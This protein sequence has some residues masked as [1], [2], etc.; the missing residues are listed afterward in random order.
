MLTAGH[1]TQPGRA[2][3]EQSTAARRT[4]M[5]NPAPSPP[6]TVGDVNVNTVTSEMA[7]VS[8]SM[9]AETPAAHSVRASLHEVHIEA[10]M[11]P[12]SAKTGTIK[13]RVSVSERRL[14]ER[15][16]TEVGVS[17]SA[18]LRR[19]GIEQATERERFE[20]IM[21]ESGSLAGE[22]GER[23]ARDLAAARGRGKR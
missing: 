7:S 22:R 2:S 4:C 5:C 18:W 13:L 16:A 15:A 19:A 11:W 1:S 12:M 20:E 14:F 21:R 23:F 6:V 9:V 17:L 10:T 3:G 8:A